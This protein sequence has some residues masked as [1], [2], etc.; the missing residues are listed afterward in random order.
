MLTTTTALT[1]R[2]TITTAALLPKALI[3]RPPA[4]DIFLPSN[5]I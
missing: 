3:R 2:T 4:L 5:P 1:H